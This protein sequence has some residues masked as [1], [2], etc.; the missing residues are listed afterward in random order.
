MAHDE[1][2]RDG[3]QFAFIRATDI[4]R[5]DVDEGWRDRM[6]RRVATPAPSQSSSST[7]SPSSSCSGGSDGPRSDGESTQP[8]SARGQ[9]VVAVVD[10][11]RTEFVLGARRV[12]TSREAAAYCGF[13]TTGAIR[14]AKSEGRLVPVGRRGGTGTWMFAIEELDRFLRGDPPGTVT[15]DRPRLPLI[16]GANHGQGEV[17]ESLEQPGRPDGAPRHLERKEGGHLVRARAVDPARGARKRSERCCRSRTKRR[18]TSG[19][20]SSEHS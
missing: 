18:R 6:A 15:L 8:G 2:K 1:Q 17:E 20:R 13:E 14:K 4:P 10:G 7:S 12:L 9:L 19:W 11:I 5:E 16:T 3:T